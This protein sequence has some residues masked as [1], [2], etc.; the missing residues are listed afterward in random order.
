MQKSCEKIQNFGKRLDASGNRDEPDDA[1]SLDNIR[2]TLGDV[3]EEYHEAK[4]LLQQFF[5]TEGE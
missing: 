5:K 3:D 2:S 4:R 1:K